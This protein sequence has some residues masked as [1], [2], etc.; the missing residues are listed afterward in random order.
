[1]T[2]LLGPP[3]PYPAVRKSGQFTCYSPRSNHVLATQDAE[4]LASAFR[5]VVTCRPHASR[6]FRNGRRT[7]GKRLAPSEVAAALSPKQ[8]TRRLPASLDSLAA[9]PG[10]VGTCRYPHLWITLCVTFPTPNPARL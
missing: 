9:Q 2:D 8:M 10:R 1:M 6:D 5:G 7:P 3:W 4:P